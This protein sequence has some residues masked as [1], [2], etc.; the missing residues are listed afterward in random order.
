M[1]GQVGR[2][3]ALQRLMQSSMSMEPSCWVKF[4]DAAHNE[5]N[6]IADSI[7]LDT[8]HPTVTNVTSSTADGIYKAGA[9]ISVNI[10]FS[11]PVVV[12][13]SF[14][15]LAMGTTPAKMQPTSAAQEQTR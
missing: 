7:I 5:S 3:I 14:E 4:R 13:G 8:S 9:T 12:T 6:V 2:R 11:E 1:T 15:T 10:Q